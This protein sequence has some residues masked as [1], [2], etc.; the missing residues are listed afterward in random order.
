M[1]SGWER[2]GRGGRKRL[3]DFGF[4]EDEKKGFLSGGQ[5]NNIILDF[6]GNI[7]LLTIFEA[8]HPAPSS[9]FSFLPALSQANVGPRGFTLLNLEAEGRGD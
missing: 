4:G 3:N 9:A 1:G 2:G 7:T 5:G 6:Y 8:S